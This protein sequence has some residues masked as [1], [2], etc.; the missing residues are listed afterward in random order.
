MTPLDA[1]IRSLARR[2]VRR[3]FGVPGGETSLDA[4]AAASAAGID[5]VLARHETGAAIMALATAEVT[6]TPGVLLTTRGP[7]LANAANGIACAALERAPLCVVSDGFSAEHRRFVT[8]QFFEHADLLAPVA[9]GSSRLDGADAAAEVERLLDAA[10]AAPSGVVHFDVTGDAVRREVPAADPVPQADP[11]PDAAALAAA[12]ALVAGARRPIVIA[13]VE[14]AADPALADSVR[15]FAAAC[16]CP[17]LVTYKAKGVIAD[18]DPAFV[19]HFTGGSA[20]AAAVGEADLILLA[21]LD[22]VE[23]IPQ[24]W[25]YRAP[26]IEIARRA[27]PVRYVE[28]AAGLYGAPAAALA[29]LVPDGRSAWTADAIARHRDAM[30]ARLAWTGQGALTP[31]AIVAATAATAAALGLDP[32][33]TVDAGAHMFSAMALWPARRPRDLLISNGLSTMGFALPA[34]IGAALA[35]PERSVVAF[36]GDGGLAMAL[37][38]L[39]TAAQTGARVVVVV[40]NDRALSLIDIKQRHRQMRRDGVDLGAVDFAA[41]ARGMGVPGYRATDPAQY[42]DALEAALRSGGPAVIDAAVEPDG[43]LDQMLALRG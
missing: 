41:V 9:K 29:A 14:A 10:M 32:R 39:A 27:F 24:A 25:R 3:M 4:I 12:R 17:A 22:P 2:G 33:V 30:R 37:G 19:G 43:Y 35:E 40:F 1:L 23:L 18:D 16:G 26:V 28:P 13:G 6:G 21:G 36:T 34:A 31:S 7:G 38:E 11:A 8:H 5:F 20:E 42:R 15:R